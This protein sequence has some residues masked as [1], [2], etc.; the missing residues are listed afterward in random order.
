MTDFCKNCNHILEMTRTLPTDLDKI[1]EQEKELLN[2][3]TPEEMSDTSPEVEANAETNAEAEAEAEANA[4]ENAEA[5]VDSES[6][7]EV[8]PERDDETEDFYEA[9]LKAIENETP[10]T[11]DQ[12]E[13]IDVKRMIKTEYY[14]SLKSKS[15][16]KK[17]ILAMIEDMG[18]SDDNTTFY[19][20]CTNCGYSRALDPGFHIMSKNPEGVASIHDYSDESKLRIAVHTGIYPRT[21]EFTCPNDKCVTLQK[22]TPTEACMMRDGDSYKMIYVCTDC[23]SI[24]RL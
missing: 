8:E 21:R 9:V 13:K 17:K 15:A 3:D 19:L 18:N 24:K 20:F 1:R 22:G 10:L 16:I 6:E 14:R 4:E 11:D 23:L 12:L 2:T 5:S 7:S